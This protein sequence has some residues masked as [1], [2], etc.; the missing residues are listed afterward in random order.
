MLSEPDAGSDLAGARTSAAATATSGGSPARRCGRATPRSSSYGMLLA[1]TNWEVPKHRGLSFF[2]C[3]AQQPGVEARPIKQMNGR[4]EFNLVHFDGAVVVRR[5]PAGWRRRGL[6]RDAHVPHLREEL[7][8]PGGPR[9][10]PVRPGRPVDARRSAR[11]GDGAG[12][13]RPRT[14][15]PWRRAHPQQ[16]RRGVRPFRRP[17]R[18]PGARRAPHPPRRSSATRTCACATPRCPG[19]RGRS[20]RSPCPTSPASSASSGSACRARTGRCSATTRRRRGS[21]TSRCRSPATSI[22]GGTDEIQRNHL[23]EKVLGLPR[24]ASTE[25]DQPFGEVAHGASAWR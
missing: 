6:G 2:L 19:S 22:A 5:Q 24:E 9:G 23:A 21:R 4:A 7:L 20:R 15:Q 3:P 10:R 25:Q 12:L 16:P 11:R 18:P 17:A 8:Q 14:W 13:G 1:R